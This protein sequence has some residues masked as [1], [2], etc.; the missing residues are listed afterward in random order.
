MNDFK[1]IHDFLKDNYEN[2]NF[3]E[4]D[5]HYEYSYQDQK[6][7]YRNDV[8]NMSDIELSYQQAQSDYRYGYQIKYY[9][10]SLI[11]II[12]EILDNRLT[13]IVDFMIGYNQAKKD[14][15]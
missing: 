6:K 5:Y 1:K 2:G 14:L 4:P 8:R 3:H 13:E 9:P 7:Y 11:K 10:V 15:K 12:N